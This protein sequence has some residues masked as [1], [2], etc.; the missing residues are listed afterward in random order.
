MQD[1][2]IGVT[3]AKETVVGVVGQMVHTHKH[4]TLGHTS[5]F[6][7]KER[8]HIAVLYSLPEVESSEYKEH[9]SIIANIWLIPSAIGCTYIFKNRSSIQI[10]S[11]ENSEKWYSRRQHLKLNISIM[12]VWWCVLVELYDQLK[13]CLTLA[14]I[15]TILT[16]TSDFVVYSD[17]F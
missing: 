6:C 4:I 15:L 10:S 3:W 16:G 12:N 2:T 1:D 17:T 14:L 5:I 8:R 9:S 11:V 7:E 13:Y